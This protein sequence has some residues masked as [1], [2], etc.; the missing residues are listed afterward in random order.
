[1]SRRAA[2]IALSVVVL[3]VCAIVLASCA[4]TLQHKPIGPSALERVI[5][6]SRFPVYWLGASFAGMPISAV[7]IDPSEAVT[8]AYGNCLVG[9]QYTCVTP[10]S[11]VTSPD[12]SFVPSGTSPSHTIDIRDVS[13]RAGRSGHT[14]AILTGAVVVSVYANHSALAT[15]AASMMTPVNKVGLPLATLPAAVP[16]TGFDRLPLPGQVP[17][18][19]TISRASGQ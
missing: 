6:K 17:A 10:L 18:G 9:G 19:V 3:C 4:D 15:V 12:N 14:L 8:I 16:D 1:M 13:A 5:V 11:I 2:R 7:T